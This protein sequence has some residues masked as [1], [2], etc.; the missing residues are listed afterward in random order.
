MYRAFIS[1][2]G[3]DKGI[4][5]REGLEFIDWGRFINKNSKVL[6][7]P[8]FTFPMHSYGITTTPGFLRAL[9]EVLKE[10][11]CEVVVAESDGGNNSFKAEDAFKNHGM[12]AI[13]R[14]TNSYLVN[15]SREP[16]VTVEGNILGRDVMVK[17]PYLLTKGVDC[18]ISV[19]VLKVHVMTTISVSVKNLWGCYPDTMRC[20]QHQNID[21]KL[22][23]II[24]SLPPTLAVVDGTYALNR[25]AP[26]YGDVVDTDLTIIADNLLVADALGC[27][28]MGLKPENARHLATCEKVGLG[29]LRMNGGVEIGGWFP[30]RCYNNKFTIERTIIDK[31]SWFLFHSDFLSRL[32]MQ[33]P[34]TPLIYWVAKFFRNEEEKDLAGVMRKYKNG[35]RG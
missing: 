34:L 10:K 13:C 19:P 33:S 1:S 32:V 7:K 14:E 3:E 21:R 22:A 20:V 30:Y 24:K 16:W 28:V 11:A 6:V 5:I 27:R 35:R 23:L 4:T 8:N 25:H 12:Y 9:L 17:L 15:L 2:L 29:T 18:V 31:V 26:L